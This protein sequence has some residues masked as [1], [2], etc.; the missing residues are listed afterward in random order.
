MV[1]QTIEMGFKF[2]NKRFRDAARG[3]RAFGADLEKSVEDATPILRQQLRF[4]LNTVAEAVAQRHGNPYP[5]GTTGGGEGFGTLSRRSGKLIE[6]IRKS[7]AVSGSKF[8]DIEGRIGSGLIYAAAQ[9]FGAV[10]RAKN[11]QFLTIPLP[12]ALDSRGVPLKKSAREWANTFVKKSKKGN[13]IIFQKI[14]RNI[15]PLYLLKREVRI[16]ARLGLGKSLTLNKK[17]FQ[18][19]VFE[20]VLDA[21]RGKL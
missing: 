12:A 7:V 21:M 9:E 15:T 14:G 1:T 8:D 2:R 5:G 11:V 6:S 4:F 13:L 17:F 10:I 18:D 3:L 19:T 20:T 16:P